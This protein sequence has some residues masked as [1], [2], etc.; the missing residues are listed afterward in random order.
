MNGFKKQEF[1]FSAAVRFA[2][3]QKIVQ[4]CK[5]IDL[6]S[7]KLK[8]FIM[9]KISLVVTIQSPCEIVELRILGLI[10]DV[11]HSLSLI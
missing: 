8:F 5:Q 7:F 3:D 2:A 9:P 10:F 6:F 1:E 11:F 4:S